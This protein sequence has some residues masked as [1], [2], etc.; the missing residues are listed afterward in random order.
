MSARILLDYVVVDAVSIIKGVSL[1]SKHKYRYSNH[2][3]TTLINLIQVLVRCPPG[4][5]LSSDGHECKDIDECSRTS[6]ICSNGICENMMGTY[7]CICND[8][9]KHIGSS[10]A[11]CEGKSAH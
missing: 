9:Y 8:G 4:L 5:E 6:G 11:H 7:Q 1:A 2:S 10:R 3:K